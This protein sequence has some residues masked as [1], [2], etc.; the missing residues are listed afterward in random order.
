MEKILIVYEEHYAV[1]S[2]AKSTWRFH[3]EKLV[4]PVKVGGKTHVKYLTMV[5]KD[6]IAVLER[7]SSCGNIRYVEHYINE[8]VF[9]SYLGD[10]QP[11]PEKYFKYASLM[12]LNYGG[13]D[14]DEKNKR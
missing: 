5:E 8:P 11:L 14:G 9:L 3:P 6:T 7:I 13:E 4:E 12:G 1:K 10:I 2:N